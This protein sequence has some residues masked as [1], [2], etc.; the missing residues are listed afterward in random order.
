MIRHTSLREIVG[1]DFL[2]TVAG[3]YLAAAQLSFLVVA[4]L[5]FQIIQLCTQHLQRLVFIFQLALFILAGNYDSGRDVGQTYRRV[6]RVDALTAVSGC[7]EYIEFTV[8]HIQMEINLFCFR[9]DGHSTGG[10]MDS[11]AGFC[12]R[13][14]LYTVYTAF[15]F[16]SGIRTLTFDHE[17][18]FLEAADTVLIKA[19]HL[20]FPATGL[21]IF[22]IHT[23]DLCRKESRLITAC[24]ST[25]LNDNVLAVIRVFRK[26]KDLQLM[27]QLLHSL[28]CIRKLLFQH[29]T[30]LFV[31]LALQHGKTVLDGFFVFLIFLIGIHNWLQVALLFHQLLKMRRIIGYSRF[32]QLIEKLFKTYQQIIQF[33]KHVFPPVS[34]Q[35]P[36]GQGPA[37]PLRSEP[38]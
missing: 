33:I 6:R 4:L 20:G 15:V 32:S 11:S 3:S 35:A 34:V 9:H 22:H 24:T 23:I 36:H 21:C 19:E 7:T 31:L 13:Y 12:L 2:R 37:D 17:S 1:T 8:V 28:S 25:D 14:S 18:N 10:S 26:K 5:L 38:R 27:L 30:H 16:Q 29:L